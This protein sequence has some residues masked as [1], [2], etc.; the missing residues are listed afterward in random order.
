MDDFNLKRF[1][2]AQSF[3]YE[4][5]LREM[6]N[7]SK[8][9]HWI[10]YIFPNLKGLGKSYNAEFYGISGLEEAIAYMQDPILSGRLIEIAKAVTQHSEKTALEIMGSSIDAIKLRS[11]MTLFREAAPE[12]EVFDDVLRIFYNGKPDFKTFSMLKKS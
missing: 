5:A 4:T 1:H 2:D 12:I 8:Q 3:S 11:C 6:Q 10:W 9:T 7:G